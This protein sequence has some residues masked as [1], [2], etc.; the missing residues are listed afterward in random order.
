ME[1]MYNLI[2]NIKTLHNKEIREIENEA[3][4]QA[5]SRFEG[6]VS[7]DK[8]RTIIESQ[9][10]GYNLKNKISTMTIKQLENRKD[11]DTEVI[12]LLKDIAKML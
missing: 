6:L 9:I 4:K 5:F 7:E 1:D 10:N 11:V 8:L 3:R 2:S 12:G